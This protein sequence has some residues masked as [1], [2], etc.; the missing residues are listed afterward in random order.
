MNKMILHITYYA[1]FLGILHK[2]CFDNATGI[3]ESD[4]AA[5]TVNGAL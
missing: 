1:Y 4:A 3:F 5:Q 2:T